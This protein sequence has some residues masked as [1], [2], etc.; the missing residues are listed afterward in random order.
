MLPGLIDRG[1]EH[2]K[3]AV[4]DKP[5]W[6]QAHLLLAQA[7]FTRVAI[8]ERTIAP[9]GAEEKKACLASSLASADDA[10]SS[11]ETEGVSYVKAQALALKSDIALLQGRKDDAAR[12][13]RESF[14]ADSSEVEGRLAMAR[15]HSVWEMW[16]K[17][18]KFWKKPMERPTRLRTLASCLARR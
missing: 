12:F 6:S 9:L 14:A 1:I 13:A 10:I 18:F 8:A 5:K 7:Y 3:D 15:P 17:V 2:A 16:M 11:A 4:A